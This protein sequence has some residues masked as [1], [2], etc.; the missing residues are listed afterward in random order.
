MARILIGTL[1]TTGH[2]RQASALARALS[3]AGHEVAWYTGSAFVDLVR[4]SGA[5]FHSM[6]TAIDLDDDVVQ[7]MHITSARKPGFASMK[8]ALLNLFIAPIPE[9]FAEMDEIAKNFQPHIIVVEHTFMA[10]LFLAEKRGLPS[11]AFSSTP[12][13]MPSTDTAPFGAG[14]PPG[15]ST[16]GRARNRILN[17]SVTR[18]VLGE[19]QA[20]A[21]AVRRTLSLPELSS[22]FMNWG[23][24]LST[25]FLAATIPDFEYPR[26][27]LSSRV[28]FT[29]ALIPPEPVDWHPPAW[30]GDIAAARDDGRPVVVVTQGATAREPRRLLL[31][32]VAALATQNV[33]VIGTTGG[34]DP[35]RVFPA[36]Q[37][38]DNFR[39]ARFLPFERLLP[40]ADLLVTN[41]GYGGVQHALSLGIPLVVAGNSEDK[42]EVNARVAWSG[43]GISLGRRDPSA[44]QIGRAVESVLTNPQYWYR[45]R[46]LQNAYARLPG[47]KLAVDA[48]VSAV[49]DGK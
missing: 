15:R 25:R 41:G 13:N 45:A 9:W 11:V 29:G 47:T 35:E 34:P 46:E 10:G 26:S 23:V 21:N 49:T 8:W 40:S 31:P 12:L 1:P 33:L 17:A 37:R 16:V 7:Q 3:A 28:E 30:W 24:E 18:W 39:L 6:S 22:S 27:D 5:T 36:S 19:P 32:A 42:M 38:P 14:L 20:A 43:A 4:D 2:V 48:I 44:D